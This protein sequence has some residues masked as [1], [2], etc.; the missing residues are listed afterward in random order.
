[1]AIILRRYKVEQHKNY[2]KSENANTASDY[3]GT[4]HIIAAAT[5]EAGINP[6]RTTRSNYKSDETICHMY[7]VAN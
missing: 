4:F 1:M 5:H 6:T 2:D 7:I 3:H